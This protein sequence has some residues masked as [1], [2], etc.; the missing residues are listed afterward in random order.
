MRKDQNTTNMG[1]LG[2]EQ[3]EFTLRRRVFVTQLQCLYPSG[4]VSQSFRE[5]TFWI[6]N[7]STMKTLAGGYIWWKQ[8][9]SDIEATVSNYSIRRRRGLILLRVPLQRG[10][11]E[12]KFLQ[13]WMPIVL[14]LI[15][16]H[17]GDRNFNQNWTLSANR[18]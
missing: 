4:V 7:V 18:K 6:S 15:F 10:Y 3:E 12:S 5:I 2:I 14:K 16:I 13:E 9:N 11:D 17:I 8:L 1:I